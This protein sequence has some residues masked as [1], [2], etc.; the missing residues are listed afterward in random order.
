MASITEKKLNL[1][2]EIKRILYNAFPD[3]PGFR[4]GEI[5]DALILKFPEISRSSFNM[6]LQR[7][8]DTMCREG[9]LRKTEKG[10]KAVFYDLTTEARTKFENIH[11]DTKNMTDWFSQ[12]TNMFLSGGLSVFEPDWDPDSLEDYEKFK[13]KAS[14]KLIEELFAFFNLDEDYF[15]EMWDRYKIFKE[16]GELR[17]KWGNKL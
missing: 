15:K 14:K 11:L 8:L 1:Q 12:K 7:A 5:R 17:D 13:K 6:R 3:T 16:T 4:W 2:T 9:Q 10:H